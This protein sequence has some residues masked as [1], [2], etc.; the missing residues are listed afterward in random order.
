[1]SEKTGD[2]R[3]RL[4]WAEI[5]VVFGLSLGASAIYSIVSLIAKLTA[6]AG[7]SGQKSTINPSLAER[8]WLDL[9]YQLLGLAFGLMPVALV[10]YLVATRTNKPFAALGLTCEKLGH[11]VMVGVGLAAA[12]GLPGIGLYLAARALGLSAQIVP[13]DLGSNWWVVPVLLLAAVKASVLEEFIVVAYLFNKLE[14]LKVPAKWQI[15]I[16]ATLRGTYHLYQGFGGFV[17]NL[18][19]GLLFGYLYK[20]HGRLLPLL[21]AHFILDFVAFVGYALLSRYITLP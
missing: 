17:G 2:R 5:G 14:Q 12:I 10:V 20:R 3:K 4:Q 6:P 16:S 18:A 15:A 13:A 19:M 7:L 9:T 8:E 11:Q 1:M 21:V